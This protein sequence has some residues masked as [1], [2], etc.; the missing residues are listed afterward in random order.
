MLL[1]TASAGTGKTAVLSHRAV[2]RIADKEAGVQADAMLVLTFTDAAAEE[3]RSRI[4][5]TLYQRYM[6]TR[7]PRLRQ[8]LLLLDRAYISTIHSFCKRILTE[9]F[10]L[11]DLDPAFGILDADEQRLLK[12]ELLEETLEEA[13]ADETLTKDL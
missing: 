4:A 1:V 8:Q 13:W 10:Y 11:T 12:G 5:D 7:E 2:L 3:M 9:F 6:D